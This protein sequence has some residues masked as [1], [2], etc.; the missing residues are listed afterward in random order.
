M[1]QVSQFSSI[2]SWHSQQI[3]HDTCQSK[4]GET[5][6]ENS[7]SIESLQPWHILCV[8]KLS[9]TASTKNDNRH[10]VNNLLLSWTVHHSISGHCMRL[11]SSKI[12]VQLRRL[13]P[14]QLKYIYTA[15]VLQRYHSLTSIV[16]VVVYITV[17][18]FHH[19]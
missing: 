10:F 4:F 1:K 9:I 12:T 13:I 7:S 19:Q 5:C 3:K 2:K 18:T 14:T 16:A 6:N 15:T 17:F 8:E 11:L